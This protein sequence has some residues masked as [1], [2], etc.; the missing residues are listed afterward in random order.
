MHYSLPLSLVTMLMLLLFVK[1]AGILEY[2]PF[3]W[4]LRRVFLWNKSYWFSFYSKMIMSKF[5]HHEHCIDILIIIIHITSKI[6]YQ[7]NSTMP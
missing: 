2:S 5:S 6:N 1:F 7:L 4:A 3:P